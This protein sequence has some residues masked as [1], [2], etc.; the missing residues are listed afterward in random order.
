METRDTLPFVSVIVPA[1]NEEATI[2]DCL[3]SLKALHYP[4]GKLEII[5]VDNGSQ[6]RTYEIALQYGVKVVQELKTFTCAAA[7]NRGILE[8]KGE[9]IAF[10]DADAVADRYWLINALNCMEQNQADIVGGSIIPLHNIPPSW[11]EIYDILFAYDQ[12]KFIR[13]LH[14]TA[15]VNTIARYKVFEKV[16]LFKSELH[17]SEDME[18][19]QRAY[20]SGA[21]IIFC[22]EAVV[23]HVVKK[24]WGE[25]YNRAWKEGFYWAQKCKE[26]QKTFME[27]L[28]WRFMLSPG[29]RAIIRR[30]LQRGHY[31][32]GQTGMMLLLHNA[33]KIPRLMGVLAAYLGGSIKAGGASK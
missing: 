3:Q 27:A 16:G 22:P 2:G 18:W 6:D 7:K 17:W 32:F 24:S 8:A 1:R 4:P 20:R 9:V 26:E 25:L 23:Y 30:K 11:W 5:V 13:E 21:K 19:G 12:E 29:L 31:R 10:I 28:R 14:F 15:G 33:L